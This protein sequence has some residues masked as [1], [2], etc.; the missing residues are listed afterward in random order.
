MAEN[1]PATLDDELPRNL[2]DFNAGAQAAALIPN[3][4]EQTW[5]VARL[6]HRAEMAPQDLNTIEKIM[7]VLMHGLEVGVSPMQAVQG[8]ALINK[9]PTIWGDLPL[10]LIFKSGLMEAFKETKVQKDNTTIAICVVKRK[11][12]E[13]QQG[14]FSLKQAAEAGLLNKSS[15]WKLY[16]DRMLQLRARAFALRDAF[17]DVLK[18]LSIGEELEGHTTDA[19]EVTPQPPVI[20]QGKPETKPDPKPRP[21]G[22]DIPEQLK[23]TKDAPKERQAL[24]TSAKEHAWIEKVSQGLAACKDHDSFNRFVTDIVTPGNEELRAP[25]KTHISE[26]VSASWKKLSASLLGN[27]DAGPVGASGTDTQA[28]GT[29]SA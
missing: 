10:A 3:T 15:T 23:R 9:R 27:K 24:V 6:I 13:Q 26:L 22:L 20:I 4:F 12:F 29:D 25:V 19:V 28:V 2:P 17:P 7:V 16:P 18:G 1:L 11:G 21:D 5:R 14:E 8:I